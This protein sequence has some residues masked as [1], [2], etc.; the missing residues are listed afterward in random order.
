MKVQVIKD[1]IKDVMTDAIIIGIYEGVKSLSSA[2]HSIDEQLGGIISEMIS[3]ESFKGKEGETLL[4]HSLGKV[5]AKKILLLGLGQEEN[6]KED[7]IRRLVAKAVKE[8]EKVKAATVAIMPIGLDRNIAAEVVGQCI[9][10]GAMLALYKFN[11]YKTTD[12]SGPE[13]GIKEVYIL[14]E[15]VSTNERLERGI[16]V[17]EKLANG[18]IIARD[19]VNEPSNVL[20]PTA[21]S[22]KAI[23][24]ANKHGLEVSILEKEDMEK[25]GMG[26]FLG[27]TKGSEEPPKLIAIKYFGNKNNDEI[28]GLVGKGLT[29]DSGGI[30]LKPGAGMDEMKNDMGGGASVLGAMDVIGALKPKVNVIGIVGACENMPSG[31]AYKPGDILTSMDG[32]TIEVLNTDA[33]G[34]LVLIDCITYAIQQGA[35]KLVDIAT[36]TGACIVAL[37]NITTALISNNDDFVKQVEK[38]AENAGER[39]WQLPSFPEYK[40]LIKSDIADL[41]NVGVRGAGT[42]TAGLFLGEF[43]GDRPWVHMDIAGTVMT[44]SDKGYNV[45]GAT[46]V[47]VRT[48][49]HLV[50]SMEK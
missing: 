5:P 21:M 50:K 39:V 4:V 47:A 45:K 31:K 40:E 26:S 10:E 18:T 32:K 34:R 15:D 46:G 14:N 13:V 22:N 7:T 44:S 25:L 3:N 29:F 41:K 48:L 9:M 11:K 49:Y 28:I 42:I 43:V 38:A 37:G 23:E 33:E 27:V 19:L 35:T 20:T 2:L 12:K 17:G 36:L 6:L 8:V 1:Q 24:I 30:S 16:G